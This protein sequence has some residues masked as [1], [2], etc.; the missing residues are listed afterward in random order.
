MIGP[1]DKAEYLKAVEGCRAAMA[2]IQRV[3][4]DAGWSDKLDGELPSIIFPVAMVIARIAPFAVFV[5]SPGGTAARREKAAVVIEETVRALASN[6]P[7]VKRGRRRV[8]VIR[9][10]DSVTL[11]MVDLQYGPA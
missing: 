11:T 8:V 10:A 9:D 6:S 7:L 5:I 3:W 4:A 2:E 1:S